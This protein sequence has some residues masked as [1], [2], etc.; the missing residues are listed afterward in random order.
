MWIRWIWS[1]FASG[2]A[3]LVAAYTKN[4]SDIF[5]ELSVQWLLQ[6]GDWNA[7]ASSRLGWTPAGGGGGRQQSGTRYFILTTQRDGEH[8]K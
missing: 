3:T 6:A 5:S 1:G 7:V 2:S 4:R 8:Y